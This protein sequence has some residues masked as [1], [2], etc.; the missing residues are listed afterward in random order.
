MTARKNYKSDFDAILHL[1]SCVGDTNKEIGWPDYDWVARFYTT[2][3]DNVY[4]ASN[5]GGVLTNCFN[6]NGNIHVVF[7]NHGL[8]SGTLRVEFSAEIPNGIYPDGSQLEV[9]PQPLDIELVRG[10]GDCGTIVDVD[11]MLSY[12]KGE[13]GDTG[14]QGPKG[15]KGDKGESFTYN[16]FTPQQIADLKKPAT[17]AAKQLQTFQATAEANESER[18]ENEDKRVQ[19]ETSRAEEFATWESEIDSKADKSE[20]SNV[21]AEE[22]LTPDN[23]P[24]INAYTRE[25][26]K[27]D[28]F[29]DM[30]KARGKVDNVEYASYDESTKTFGLNGIDGIAYSEAVQIL[31]L[32]EGLN[33]G[34]LQEVEVDVNKT[35]VRTLMPITVK[36]NY[37]MPVFNSN[38]NAIEVLCFTST[39]AGNSTSVSST[40]SFMNC[41]KLKRIIGKEI[42]LRY[43]KNT[44]NLQNCTE[45]E[46]CRFSQLHS[47]FDIH[48]S[49]KLG[50]D[51]LLFLVDNSS[52]TQAITVTVHPSVYSKITDESNS[53]WHALLAQAAEKNITFATT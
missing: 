35:G 8:G 34:Y 51:S 52:N 47:D 45:L 28:L 21:I 36:T 41:T 44:P 24:D 42:S 15:D 31:V 50:L 10:R 11:V 19:A 49:G 5:I 7:N 27:M 20:L 6:D 12:I 39:N 29:I 40:G 38:Y 37:A 33:H 1:I 14:P 3:Q 18:E 13:K 22:P 25:E 4:I 2:S 30:W 17:D 46:Y 23:F 32:S 43:S 53:E 26:L 16:D 48:W 9:S